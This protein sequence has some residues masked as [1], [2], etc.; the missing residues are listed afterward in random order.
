MNEKQRMKGIT[1]VMLAIYA[2]AGAWIGYLI[3][4]SNILDG[5]LTERTIAVFFLLL[6]F[7]FAGMLQLIIHEAG[8]LIFGL[9]TG[10]RF[11][12]FRI[13]GTIWIKL[14]GRLR[15]RRYTLA[16]TGG[17]CLMCPPDM[18]DGSFP[19]V[20]Y[21]LGGVML[22][23]ASGLL[24]LGLYL[25]LGP[26]QSL[27]IFFMELTAT[28]FVLALTNGIPMRGLTDN[29][30]RNALSLR[31]D[32]T[33]LRAFWLQL[34]INDVQ[35]EGLRL[36]DMPEEWFAEPEAA[37]MRNALIA[38]VGIAACNRMMDE[39]RFEEA[40]EKMARLLASDANIGGLH[41]ALMVC[42]RAFC[43]LIAGRTRAEIDALLG[44]KAQRKVM[45]L[46]RRFPSVMRTEYAY[47]LL[48]EDD[49][50]RAKGLLSQFETCAEAYPYA[51]EIQSER[52]L[53]QIAL[54]AKG[55]V[56]HEDTCGGKQRI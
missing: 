47:A 43:G 49:A 7:Y 5:T 36:R 17:Q 35:R 20:L 50:L 42:D 33:A 4:D 23:T 56:F 38:Y 44:D 27:S 34:K 26:G 54:E 15:R 55:K 11:A 24:A 22:N 10:Y 53:I 6:G 12:S 52:E 19:A 46:M 31:R 13:G 45:K 3:G 37:K 2:G 29:D 25:W 39:H 16:G 51:A 14:D 32:P 30:G 1:I 9:L 41:R 28:G 21:N 48:A 18:I 8:H 40:D